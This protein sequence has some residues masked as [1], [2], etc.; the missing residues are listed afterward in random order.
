[1]RVY[2]L[3]H[4]AALP[5]APD[6]SDKD[7]TLSPAG[8]ERLHAVL[9]KAR[10]AGVR[11]ARILSSPY[12]RARETAEMACG[13]LEC[14]AAIEQ[15]AALR[16]E[17]APA[18]IW[19]EVRDLPDTSEVLLVGHLPLVEHLAAFLLGQQEVRIEFSAGTMIAIQ[20]LA[21]GAAPAGELQW[22]I[23]S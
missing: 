11:P 9:E 8:R 5:V 10:S 1:M 23:Q 6:G 14:A 12:R 20:M 2:V 3:R 4:G 16:P 18:D 21:V 19:S 22:T 17:A 15:T 13:L 7:R